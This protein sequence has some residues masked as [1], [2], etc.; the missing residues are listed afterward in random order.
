MKRNAEN[1]CENEMWQLGCKIKLEINEHY[2][3][4][5]I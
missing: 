3:L 4:I 5:N 1:E 2:L